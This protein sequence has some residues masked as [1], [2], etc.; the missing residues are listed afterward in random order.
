MIKLIFILVSFHNKLAVEFHITGTY[1]DF[2]NYV[3]DHKYN[4]LCEY[5]IC[6]TD[7]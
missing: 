5:E 2:L 6:L 1:K 7:E 3:Y 4:K